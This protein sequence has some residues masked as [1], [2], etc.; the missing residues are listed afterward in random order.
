VCKRL[1]IA[2]CIIVLGDRISPPWN[3]I[4]GMMLQ[5]TGVPEI[6]L[7]AHSDFSI[8][9]LRN[10]AMHTFGECSF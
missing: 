5:L 6:V 1:Q 2:I 7:L 3:G 4:I 10:V 8:G 9:Y